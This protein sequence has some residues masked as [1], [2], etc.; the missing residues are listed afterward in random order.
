METSS[1]EALM[2]TRED[3]EVIINLLKI[4]GSANQSRYRIMLCVLQRREAQIIELIEKQK[5]EK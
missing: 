5:A 4:K 3:I 2:K 1:S